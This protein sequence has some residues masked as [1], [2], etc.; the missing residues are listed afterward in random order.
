MTTSRARTVKRVLDFVADHFLAVPIG[1]V[2]ALHGPTVTPRGP[3]AGL[4]G[5]ADD[6]AQAVHINRASITL[7]MN[8]RRPCCLPHR[9]LDAGNTSGRR[10]TSS[11]MLICVA[12]ANTFSVA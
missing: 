3:V 8:A 1:A 11:R 9:A 5:A 2:I 12:L 4:L 7:K 10:A 6:T